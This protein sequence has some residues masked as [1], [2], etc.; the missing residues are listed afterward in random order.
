MIHIHIYVYYSRANGDVY[1]DRTMGGERYA[2]ERVTELKKREW[3][4][5][6]WHQ[7]DTYPGAF[8]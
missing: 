6:A 4:K 3:V 2:N 8:Y 7:T 5:D 1:Y